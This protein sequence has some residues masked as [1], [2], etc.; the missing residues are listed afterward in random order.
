MKMRSYGM[1]WRL[2]P[3]YFLIVAVLH[4]SCSAVSENYQTVSKDYQR[5]GEN[6]QN[7][8]GQD[9]PDGF[10][11]N[12]D[13]VVKQIRAGLA[14]YASTITVRFSTVDDI[15]DEMTDVAENWVE[16]ALAET[17]SPTEGDYI[18]YQYG[19][20]TSRCDRTRDGA[21]WTYTLR[22]IPDYYGYLIEEQEASAA[23]EELLASPDLA[24]DAPAAEKIRAIYDWLCQNVQYDNVNG[25]YP[26]YHKSSTAHAALVRRFA[27]C[28]G[29]CVALYRLLRSSGISCRIVTGEAESLRGGLHAWI[30][31]AV[32]G[33]YY[34]LD[35][36]WDAGQAE[37][38]Y[39]LVGET[40]FS[41]HVAGEAFRTEAFRT[42]YPM[43]PEDYQP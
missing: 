4:T 15:L 16:A 35:P 25:K 17:D 42:Q 9:A 41:D 13:E 19:G 29:Y 33:R 43:A 1:R 39:F 38:R 11:A 14:R 22:I 30:I 32:D 5:A 2:L 10:I 37:Y 31:A 7:Q 21:Q 20:Y 6:D 24:P 28:Q 27:T 8:G 23:A 26:H 40:H 36:T 3:L 18:R 12:S 34:N